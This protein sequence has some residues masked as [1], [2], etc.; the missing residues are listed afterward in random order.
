ME[1]LDTRIVAL[2]QEYQS[3][4][5]QLSGRAATLAAEL[6]SAQSKLAAAEA[7][8]VELTPKDEAP[9]AAPTPE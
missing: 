2:A 9:A 3:H 7:R 1:D 5:A 6:A 8:I 4:V